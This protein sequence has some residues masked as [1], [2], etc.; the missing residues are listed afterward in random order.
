[1]LED[2]AKAPFMLLDSY[3]GDKIKYLLEPLSIIFYTFT[4]FN[5]DLG[6]S[7]FYFLSQYKVIKFI[8]HRNK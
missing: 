8:K 4:K 6:E 1:M 5:E 7:F 2:F 3:A